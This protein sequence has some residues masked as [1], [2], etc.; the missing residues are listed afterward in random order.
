MIVTKPKP[1]EEVLGSVAKHKRIF[2]VGCGSC[3]TAWH[4]GGEPEVAEMKKTLEENGKIVTGTVV[5]EEPCDG[6]KVKKDFRAHKSEVDQADAVVVMSCGAGVQSV[7]MNV[8]VSTYPALDSL[9]LA[10]IERLAKAEEGCS[11]CGHCIL[12]STGG[13]C[14]VAS[15]PKGLLNGPCGGSQDGK[16]E[17]D[18]TQPCAWVTI[19]DRM[20]ALGRLEE[21]E[22]PVEAKDNTKRAQPRSVDKTSPLGF[23]P[24]GPYAGVKK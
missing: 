17:V 21:L 9:F 12:A 4:T 7:A 1:I 19:Y 6:R 16:C 14:P 5:V 13:V 3:S 10:R 18:P 2:I 22:E 24:K 15:C 23:T 20:K 11:L 8:N